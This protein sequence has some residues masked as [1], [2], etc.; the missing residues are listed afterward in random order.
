[1]SFSSSK[2]NPVDPVTGHA[3]DSIVLPTYDQ[4]LYQV[5]CWKIGDTE[6][7]ADSY[8]LSAADADENNTITL[9]AVWE[10]KNLGLETLTLPASQTY[11]VVELS[12]DADQSFAIETNATLT[13]T[14]R[15]VT[16]DGSTYTLVKP[17]GSAINADSMFSLSNLG[18]LDS[19][20]N[21]WVLT[22]SKDLADYRQDASW[23]HA[24]LAL[25][26]PDYGFFAFTYPAPEGS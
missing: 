5:A 24:R 22:V 12:G 15:L 7:H 1:M 3:G 10:R 25:N 18:K 21:V 19:G 6:I 13:V 26:S 8:V 17:D 9:T 2:G 11:T 4:V 20:G 23:T 14:S 16:Y